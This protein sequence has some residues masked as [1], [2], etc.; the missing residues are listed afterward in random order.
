MLYWDNQHKHNSIKL[1]SPR[2]AKTTLDCVASG[3]RTN[4]GWVSGL[5][6]F[7]VNVIRNRF[8]NIYV[9]IADED[10]LK[11]GIWDNSCLYADNGLIFGIG[12]GV[13]TRNLPD[14]RQSLLL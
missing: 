10:A 1:L 4:I 2:T 14:K 12:K 3:G 6:R 8:R 5:H 11:E 13:Q 9:G 7:D